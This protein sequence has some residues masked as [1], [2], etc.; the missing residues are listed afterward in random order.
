[1]NES[2]QTKTGELITITTQLEEN[3][4]TLTMVETGLQKKQK[5]LELI[6]QT[7]KMPNS[8]IVKHKLTLSDEIDKCL[9]IAE[10]ELKTK[11]IDDSNS[12]EL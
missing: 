8:N 2:I 10:G 9:D 1:L 11:K 7:D 3:K 5:E 6:E 12:E 4:T